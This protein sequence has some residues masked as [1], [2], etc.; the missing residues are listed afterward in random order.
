MRTARGPLVRGACKSAWAAS[1]VCANV[2]CVRTR[3]CMIVCVRIIVCVNV[4]N[5]I[6]HL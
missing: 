2:M 3:A 4:Q 1:C 6:T 5:E